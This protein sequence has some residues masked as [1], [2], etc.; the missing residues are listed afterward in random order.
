L[1]HVA[2][3][4]IGWTLTA[5]SAQPGAVVP[6]VAAQIFNDN[7]VLQQDM[8]IPVWGT[9][10]PGRKVTVALAGA[11]Q[12]ATANVE[13]RWRVTLPP[14]H[15]GAGAL[16]L[17]ILDDTGK[18]STFTNVV[19]G[20]VWLCS[21][22]SN[23]YWPLKDTTGA[24]AEIASADWHG[25]RMAPLTV[26][27]LPVPWRVCSTQTAG[28]FPAV[29]YYFARSLHAALKVPV[30]IVAR[31]LPN[32]TAGHWMPPEAWASAPP[33]LAAWARRH[34]EQIS[35]DQ[36]RMA[37]YRKARAEWDVAAQAA[38]AAR[39]APPQSPQ[40]PD[41]GPLGKYWERQI[42]PLLPMALRGVIWYQG[43]S[44]AGNADYRAL[45][46]TMISGWRAAW[47]RE[48]PFYFVQLPGYDRGGAF[49]EI[50]AAQAHCLAL[51]NTGMAV[52]IDTGD[53]DLHPRRKREVGERL[54]LIALH[55][56]YGQ[57]AICS[58]PVYERHLAEGDSVRVFFRESHGGLTAPDGSPK[59]FQIAGADGKFVPAEARIDGATV[60]VTHPDIRNPTAVRYAWASAP[61]ATLFNKADLPA[62][63]FRSDDNMEKR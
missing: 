43:E 35:T 12:T 61:V 63:P 3:V 9:A 57:D 51:P 29:G 54:A 13:G 39:T 55:K 19:A 4:A 58:G 27:T 59:G 46:A 6:T 17:Q 52:T 34:A 16:E 2:A 33:E 45:F 25:I 36:S 44:D 1:L 42:K 47:G 21:G 41:S 5:C 11:S 18:G 60:V 14:L 7:M 62:A 48:L 40:Y 10:T 15:A 50:R 32:T 38:R 49:P 8:D 37:E 53:G 22:Q 24:P 31:A 28:A 26:N 23:M 56:T 20:E 30:G